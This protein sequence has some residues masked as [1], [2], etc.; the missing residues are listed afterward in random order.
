MRIGK[1]KL[2]PQKKCYFISFIAHEQ[3]GFEM[4]QAENE[5]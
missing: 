3:K 5:G 2:D 1:V 4:S